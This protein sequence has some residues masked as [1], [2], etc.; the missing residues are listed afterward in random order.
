[1][2]IDI[3]MDPGW[4]R[5]SASA[6]VQMLPW[7]WVEVQ[8]T[9]ISITPA[10]NTAPGGWAPTWSLMVAGT[11]ETNIGS[12]CGRAMGPDTALRNNPWPDIA[13]ALDGKQASHISQ[14]LA[15][16]SL[17]PRGA[18]R[19][20]QLEVYIYII[21]FWFC[22]LMEF[23][24]LWSCGSLHLYLL[25]VPFLDFFLLLVLLLLLLF[26]RCFFVF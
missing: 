16:F 2:S 15:S 17:E 13:M 12:G 22:V 1:M 18:G 14:F 11:L 25:L 4:G 21:G 8:A 3:N 9:Q 10:T 20:L 26:P 5:S 7:P 24:S 19:T 6:Q 23:L